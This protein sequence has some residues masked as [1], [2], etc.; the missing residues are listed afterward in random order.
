MRVLGSSILSQPTPDAGLLLPG[1]QS[2]CVRMGNTWQVQQSA[3]PTPNATQ[4]PRSPFQPWTG[5]ILRPPTRRN[6]CF[7]LSKMEKEFSTNR[8]GLKKGTKRGWAPAP[9]SFL[10]RLWGA[11]HLSLC[12]AFFQYCNLLGFN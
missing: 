3:S 10:P 1:A 8:E 7:Y 5:L 12:C 6:T 4:Y 11:I 2:L 9:S